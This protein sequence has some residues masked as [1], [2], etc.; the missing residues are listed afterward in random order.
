MMNNLGH[1]LRYYLKTLL[2]NKITKLSVQNMK[3]KLN[4]QSNFV[5]D[6]IYPTPVY[7]EASGVSH[8]VYPSCNL[9][10]FIVPL[11]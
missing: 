7:L 8:P 11:Y 6:L 2:I 9:L 3:A 10:L 1:R 4:Q 5:S